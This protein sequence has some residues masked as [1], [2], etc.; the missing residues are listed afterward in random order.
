MGGLE[1]R[2][3]R[4]ADRSFCSYV[5]KLA[6]DAA[7]VTNSPAQLARLAA[8]AAGEAAPLVDEADYRFFRQRYPLGDPDESALV[9]LTD[10]TIR[11]WCGPRQRIGASRRTRAVAV[12]AELHARHAAALQAGHGADLVLPAPGSGVE[13]LPDVGRLVGDAHAVRSETYGSLHFA[14]PV[15]ELDLD[16]VSEEEA[17]LYGR[18]RDGYAMNWT[19]W[20]D[21]IALRLTVDAERLAADL[22]VRP[23]IAGTEYADVRDFAGRSS[24]NDEQGR[25][26]GDPHA[27]SLLHVVTAFD[28]EARSVRSNEFIGLAGMLAPNVDPL[29]WIG[30]AISFSLDDDPLWKQMAEDEDPE[31]FLSDHFLQ[32]PVS[33]HVEVADGLRLTAFLVALRAMAQQS[34]P[35]M[36]AWTNHEHAGLSYVRVGLTEE[37][38]RDFPFEEDMDPALFYAASGDGLHL[39]LNEDVVRRHLE[40]RVARRGADAAGSDGAGADREAVQEAVAD[41]SQPLTTPWPGVQAAVALDRRLVDVIASGFVGRGEQPMRELAWRNLPILDEWKRMF[42]DADPVEV[43]ERLYGRTLLCPGGGAFRYSETDGRMESTLYG[44]PG[45]PR[46]GPVMPALADELRSA[47]MGLEFERDGL[48]ARAELRRDGGD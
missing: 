31:A 37:G 10:A 29:G 17:L 36:L 9:V 12:L 11:R 47:R 19:R 1:Y 25:P 43:H 5:A 48:R 35:G 30:P 44:H 7:V 41:L 6:D 27:E 46:R 15:A 2:A 14:T 4:S 20:F 21:P 16:R 22:T 39:S 40:R 42:P 8:V 24:I 23:L 45:R 33:L 34:A 3:M 18:W 38:K 26:L 28:K 32:L 13:D